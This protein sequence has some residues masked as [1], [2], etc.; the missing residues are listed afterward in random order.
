ML[1]LI[2][3]LYQIFVY[4]CADL[5]EAIAKVSTEKPK[6]LFLLRGF[7]FWLEVSQ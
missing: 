7:F 4:N 2:S 6:V 3:G 5:T 1:N